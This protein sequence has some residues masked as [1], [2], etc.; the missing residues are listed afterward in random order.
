MTAQQLENFHDYLDGIRT[1]AAR[2]FPGVGVIR[3]HGDAAAEVMRASAPEV[4]MTI[5]VGANPAQAIEDAT[6]G[7]AQGRGVMLSCIAT[8]SLAIERFLYTVM[9]EDVTIGTGAFLV[10][11]LDPAEEAQATIGR[12]CSSWCDLTT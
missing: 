7:L 5:E 12:Y 1:L 10:L 4:A 11:A 9:N 8:P 2:K 3:R 6:L